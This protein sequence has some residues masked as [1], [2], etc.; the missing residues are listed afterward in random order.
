MVNKKSPPCLRLAQ[1][2]RGEKLIFYTI[3]LS[4]LRLTDEDKLN[5][6]H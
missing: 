1:A 2:D 4:K 5:I 3:K 6:N